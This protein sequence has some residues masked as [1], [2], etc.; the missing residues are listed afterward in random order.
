MRLPPADQD[1]RLAKAALFSKFAELLP[2]ALM[3]QQAPPGEAGGHAPADARALV[4]DLLAAIREVVAGDP[5][6]YQN[7]FRRPPQP[8]DIL[9]LV[10]CM[11]ELA[12]ACLF[13]SIVSGCMQLHASLHLIPWKQ[14]PASSLTAELL[15]FLAQDVGS[16]LDLTPVCMHRC[17]SA[18]CFVQVVNLLNADYEDAEAG[19]AL[20]ESVLATLTAL[21]AGNDASRRRLA[22]DVGYDQI[23]TAVARQVRAPDLAR[24]LHSTGP[25]RLIPCAACCGWL[26]GDH[27]VLITCQGT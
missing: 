23:L 2:A 1:E 24:L 6:P 19:A 13:V 26:H 15:E 14:G 17:R 18:E 11:E 27:V 12:C 22:A 8:L 20:A 4:G 3:L 7:L 5:L 21:L 16:T 10:P 9:H 25:W